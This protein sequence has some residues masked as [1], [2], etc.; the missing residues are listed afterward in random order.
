M[1]KNNKLN[2]EAT[3]SKG[4][5][6]ITS[7]DQKV[8]GEGKLSK[9]IDCDDFTLYINNEGFKK[10]VETIQKRKKSDGFNIGT[11]IFYKEVK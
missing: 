2:E 6:K 5:H 10:C 8:D 9:I 11:V 3:I 4:K 1:K 7:V